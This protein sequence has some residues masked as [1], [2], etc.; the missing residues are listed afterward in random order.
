MNCK[1]QRLDKDNPDNWQNIESLGL[2]VAATYNAVTK[3]QVIYKE[4]DVKKLVNLLLKA[5]LVVTFNGS[6]FDYRVLS[7][8]T[9]HNLFE[10]IKSFSI[11]ENVEGDLWQRLSLSNLARQNLDRHQTTTVKH[12]IEC[13][14]RGLIRILTDAVKY[15]LDSIVKL[16]ELGCKRKFLNYWCPDDYTLKSFK[17]D[18]WA[19]TCQKLTFVNRNYRR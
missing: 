4:K 14:Q 8:Y 1:P 9:D 7:A 13:Y 2:S 12:Q 11:L 15:D 6:N 10:Q 3:K 5:D 19:K 17:T 18:S 16:F